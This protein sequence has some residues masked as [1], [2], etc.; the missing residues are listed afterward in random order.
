MTSWLA[1]IAAIKYIESAS[2]LASNHHL[3]VLIA[4]LDL[5]N[6]CLLKTP[7]AAKSLQF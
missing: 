5:T 2:P 3:G 4:K 7:K 6:L 1:P